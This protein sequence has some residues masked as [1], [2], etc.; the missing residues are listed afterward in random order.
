V[1]LALLAAP[2]SAVRNSRNKCIQS[3]A[4]DRGQPLES[5]A[6]SLKRLAA[7][8]YFVYAS[9]RRRKTSKRSEL[10]KNVQALRLM[11]P[12]RAMSQRQWPTISGAGRGLYGL[13]N[14]AGVA[15]VARLRYE[16]RRV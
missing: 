14:N 15:T 4:R 10:S 11:S 1:L 16:C 6:R 13:V 5:A 3:S 2:I 9:A 8:G 12:S 7:D